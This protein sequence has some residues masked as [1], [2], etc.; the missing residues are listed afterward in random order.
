MK[1]KLKK[2]K[3]KA[4][5]DNKSNIKQMMILSVTGK[6]PFWNKSGKLLQGT[7]VLPQV[8]TMHETS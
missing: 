3:L 5:A 4:F 1:K 2:T 8:V 6:K 7:P